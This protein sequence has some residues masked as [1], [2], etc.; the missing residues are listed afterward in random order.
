M[1]S[2]RRNRS[3]VVAVALLL[4]AGFVPL[5]R[6]LFVGNASAATAYS[7]TFE[8]SPGS[9]S[10]WKPSDWDVTVHSRDDATRYEL[11]SMDAMHGSDC[12][13]PPATHTITSYDD[14]VFICKNHMMT[15]IKAGGYGV[16]Y[17]TPAHLLDFSESK[18]AVSWD[19]S[20]ARTSQRDWVDLWITP[21]EDQLQ[22]PLQPSLQVDLSGPPKRAI[23]IMMNTFNGGTNF[24]AEVYRDY[25]ATP[26][27][28]PG[29]GFDN[30]ENHFTPDAARRDNF[31]A[32]LTRSHLT[33]GM[34]AYGLTWIDGDIPGGPL[35]WTAGVVQFGHH[36]YNPLKDCTASVPCTAN[37]W[38]WDNISISPSTPFSIARA[39]RR[40]V[41]PTTPPTM[42]F[43]SPAPT[44]AN[45]RFAGIGTN[46]EVS[47][48][49]GAT[50]A[51]AKLQHVGQPLVE[52]HAKSYWTP[53]PAGATSATFRG[54]N[55]WCGLWMV[56]DASIW[57]AS[58]S[59]PTPVTTATTAPTTTTSAP[60]TTTAL[61]A[62]TTTSAPATTTAPTPTTASI[63]TTTPAPATTTAT[64]TPAPATTTTP[65]PETT[66]A[67]TSPAAPSTSKP[68]PDTTRPT[69]PENL[70]TIAPPR[71]TTPA[72][73]P[74]PS[75]PTP[76]AP[77]ASTAP[78]T[79]TSTTAPPIAAPLNAKPVTSSLVAR[80]PT[81]GTTTT[82]PATTTTTTPLVTS[83][84]KPNGAVPKPAS[85]PPA[86]VD[87]EPPKL[88]T[89][90]SAPAPI[91]AEPASP[92]AD[93][94]ST[95]E[96]PAITYPQST[97]GVAS[98]SSAHVGP[99][100]APPAGANPAPDGAGA[101]PELVG[102]E[103]AVTSILQRQPILF[104]GGTSVLTVESRA[105]LRSIAT[106]LRNYRAITI[107][108]STRSE[109]KA[110]TQIKSRLV[111]DRAKE[112]A[113]HLIAGGI[114]DNRIVVQ[115][116]VGS[117]ASGGTPHQRTTVHLGM[118]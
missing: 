21:Y 73:A 114:S 54:T 102:L 25:V 93:A 11:E 22:L 49:R 95:T 39:D 104:V 33:F 62:A 34:P 66:T 64:T 76:T 61:A 59:S 71:T 100:R 90:G 18:G 115:T 29:S 42:E 86:F 70:P 116:T 112:I 105:S 53:M 2:L 41:D 113:R 16:V 24:T 32:Q 94:P 82:L 15:S 6:H 77:A 48:D 67:T 55:C 75:A 109:S 80:P 44:G 50:W 117:N 96:A 101:K 52:E 91:S 107:K 23:H 60:A 69:T 87:P 106:L 17:L 74:P 19:M 7:E 47:F 14:A 97:A 12:A 58:N 79:T 10:P 72:P 118:S 20:T 31:S 30:Y 108:V 37:T 38:H 88:K 3:A 85:T 35:D 9:P 13:S 68:S 99:L 40:F 78:S 43:A 45:L 65:A 46:L 51:T 81:A 4:I 26:I 8:T 56:R 83:L 92:S 84:I 89:G 27:P 36:S 57:S 28:G 98:S 111:A 110:T 103:S 1:H 63:T 5:S